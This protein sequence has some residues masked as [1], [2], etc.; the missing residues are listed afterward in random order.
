ME[1][2]RRYLSG[3]ENAYFDNGAAEDWEHFEKIKQGAT[4]EDIEKIKNVY[5]NVPDTLIAILEY[6][7]GTYWREYEG[8][9]IS[10]YFLGSDV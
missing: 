9:E 2:V 8:E 4:K 3:I 7:D 5:S 10:F 1:I 6:V